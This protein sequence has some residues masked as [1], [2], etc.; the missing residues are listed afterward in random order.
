MRFMDDLAINGRTGPLIRAARRSTAV[1]TI[2]CNQ[3]N[4][5]RCARTQQRGKGIWTSRAGQSP[6]S[7]QRENEHSVRSL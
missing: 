5:D 7:R 6:L 2:S 3:S 1:D 4:T